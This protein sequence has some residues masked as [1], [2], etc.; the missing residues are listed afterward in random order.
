MEKD[1]FKQFVG[2][3][4]TLIKNKNSNEKHIIINEIKNILSDKYLII[5]FESILKLIFSN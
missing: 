4:K 3:I 1:K 2:L 5:K